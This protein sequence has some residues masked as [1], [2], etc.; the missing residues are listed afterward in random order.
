MTSKTRYT[1][2]LVGLLAA[3]AEP[4]VGE[5]AALAQRRAPEQKGRAAVKPLVFLDSTRER[6]G[7]RG[8]V[9][10]VRT[11]VA[12]LAAGAGGAVVE[13]PRRLLEVTVYDPSGRRVE[14]ATYPVVSSSTGQESNV[15]D[16]RGH[17]A[18]T[19]LTDA[20]GRA[21]S[22]TV[23]AYEFD[24]R[25][26]WTKMTASLSVVGPAGPA[27][28]PV[29]I[30]YRAITYYAPDPA[31]ARP[32]GAGIAVGNRAAPRPPAAST[33]APRPSG[34]SAGATRPPTAAA[35]PP[36]PDASAAAQ[37][38]AP[39]TG[40][41]APAASPATSPAT[42]PA[43]A[44]ATT[45]A[46]STV[47]SGSGPSD[48]FSSLPDA[49]ILNHRASSLPP[50]SFPVGKSRPARGLILVVV[51]VVIDEA[52]RVLSARAPSGPQALREA[53]EEAARRA[54][55]APFVTEGVKRR[56]RGTIRYTFP[57]EP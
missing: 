36:A 42:S 51:E 17:L 56:V 8:P 32:D 31:E 27:L 38:N 2:A 18:E 55:F 10:R 15:F 43:G 20:R 3:L 52:G 28:E 7:L 1:V 54:V 25:G 16:E 33:N 39:A 26:N 11:E 30:T 34:I 46:A 12:R 23:Y 21:I 44:S 35:G 37:T 5:R 41:D 48:D 57:Y 22:R 24:G 13:G 9:R 50:P 45:A 14:N 6:D 40:R 47:T 19:V 4:A 53:A 29:E 49:G